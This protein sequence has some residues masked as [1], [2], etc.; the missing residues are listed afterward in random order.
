MFALAE[1]KPG[2]A[3]RDIEPGLSF[4]AYGLQDYRL[5]RAPDERISVGANS[6]RR[7]GRQAAVGT[8]KCAAWQISR[9]AKHRPNHGARTLDADIEA[10]LGDS[11]DVVAFATCDSGREA[12]TQGLFR[13]ED[14]TDAAV[15]VAGQSANRDLWRFRLGVRRNKRG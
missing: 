8:F 1:R 5:V 13:A 10:D 7:S 9:A 6:D 15:A 4:D 2:N 14:H 12:A 11:R 3:R